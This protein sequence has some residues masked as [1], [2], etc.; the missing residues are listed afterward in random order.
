MRSQSVQEP[1]KVFFQHEEPAFPGRGHI[2]G[3]V[4][5]DEA[6]IEDRHPGVL[7]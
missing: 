5:R 4:T 7:W 3:A 6:D 2:V 1:V